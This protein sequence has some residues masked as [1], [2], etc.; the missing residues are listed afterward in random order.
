MIFFEDTLSEQQRIENCIKKYGYAPEHNFWWYQCQA[1]NG[2]KNI[3][4]ESKNG[5]GLLTIE[6]TDKKRCKIGRAHV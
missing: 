6:E 2:S 3:F 1:E 4:A 5:S